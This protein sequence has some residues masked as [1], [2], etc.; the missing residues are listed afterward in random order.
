MATPS[1][2]KSASA[3]P[4]EFFGGED[5][6]YAE[7][8]QNAREAEQRLM[9][10]L[11]KRNESRL[12]PSMLSLAGELLDPGRTGS[13]GEALGR[14]AKSYAAAQ[15]AETKELADNAMMQMQLRN[16]QLERAQANKMANMAGP[17][18]RDFL[19]PGAPE[20]APSSPQAAAL[21]A[22][23]ELPK[24]A[25]DATSLA[26][27][28]GKLPPEEMP[29]TGQDGTQVPPV[30]QTIPVAKPTVLAPKG[31]DIPPVADNAPTLMINNRPV[32]PKIIAGLQMM[33]ATKA[34]GD[35]LEKAYNMQIKDR[36]LQFK[37]SEDARAA[38]K[39]EIDRA[40]EKRNAAKEGRDIIEF[41]RGAI[42][43]TP[44]GYIDKSDP[45]NPKSVY[46]PNP[47]EPDIE[48][49]FPEFDGKKLMGSRNDLLKLREARENK[50]RAGVEAIYNFL[51]FGVQGTP[52]DKAENAGQKDVTEKKIDLEAKTAGAKKTAELESQETA[53]FLK[54][55][56]T[57]RE[58]IFTSARIIKNAKENAGMY[59]LLKKPGVGTALMQFARDQGEQGNLAFTKENLE[60]A[61]RLANV[62]TKEMDMVKVAEMSSDLARLHFGYRK[63][64]LEKQGQVSDMEDRGIRKIQGTISEPAQYLIG[65][66]QLT[67]RKAQYDTEVAA[68]LRA[69]RRDNK[70]ATLE[71][72]RSDPKSGYN[73]V[74]S[75]Y[76]NWIMKTYKLPKGLTPQTE[77]KPA[78]KGAAALSN[79]NLDAILKKRGLLNEKK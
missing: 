52:K 10:M 66:A 32:N 26:A 72:Y 4:P 23:K 57:N 39:L 68:G 8:Y 29:A 13:F 61:L 74:L 16:M 70:G 78:N 40:A 64:L 42:K 44:W 12:S 18:I 53:D 14:G 77:T 69:Y 48:I 17:M 62:N 54:N 36:E 25:T 31:A 45:K 22:K 30:A 37:A 1:P 11:Q 34:M 75:A 21:P 73:K 20:A 59:G 19:S 24:I 27:L 35:A 5:T 2:L 47:G 56:G 65:M 43:E 50:D 46:V 55:E 49:A 60:N 33:P 28:Q 7:K 76:E 71:D 58:T 63:S 67:G 9:D 38:A 79:E 3:L 6:D 51:R 15:G 41:E